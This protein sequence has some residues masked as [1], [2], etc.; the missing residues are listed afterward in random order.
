VFIADKTLYDTWIQSDIDVSVLEEMAERIGKILATDY[1]AA[2][3]MES[4]KKNRK[5]LPE[6]SFLWRTKVDLDN[7]I[8]QDILAQPHDL[9]R[10]LREIE[11]G[12]V[13]IKEVLH[14]IEPGA[15]YE[16]ILLISTARWIRRN[17]DFEPFI[18]SDDRDLLTCGHM[19]SSFFGLS[20]GFLSGF[21]LLRLMNRHDS[22]KKYCEHYELNSQVGSVETKWLKEPLVESLED[23]V[24][25]S[26]VA[27]HPTLGSR[28]RLSRMIRHRR[29]SEATSKCC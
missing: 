5:L 29:C 18:I 19:V 24:R 26:K 23:V 27:F 21:E 12:V 17:T 25:A 20:L 3:V 6:Q 14:K 16:D 2:E 13:S 15:S 4:I 22:F 10:A 28:D 8:Y 11:E 9:A 1:T 7:K